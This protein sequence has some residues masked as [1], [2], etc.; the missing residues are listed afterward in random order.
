[1]YEWTITNLIVLIL[2]VSGLKQIIAFDNKMYLLKSKI[3]NSVFF[4]VFCTVIFYCALQ[5][6]PYSS[7]FIYLLAV[8]GGVEFI[9]QT[10]ALLNKSC[11]ISILKALNNITGKNSSNST[12]NNNYKEYS[13]NDVMHD[14]PNKYIQD[15]NVNKAPSNSNQQDILYYINRQKKLE[16]QLSDTRNKINSIKKNKNLSRN[17]SHQ[18]TNNHTLDYGNSIEGIEYLKQLVKQGINISPN[19]QELLKQSEDKKK[20]N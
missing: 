15:K 16:K 10:Y 6:I 4:S 19:L 5:F 2:A 13:N 20:N 11:D 12:E 8:I 1:M 3:F 18:L 17:K 7:I 14:N 9:K